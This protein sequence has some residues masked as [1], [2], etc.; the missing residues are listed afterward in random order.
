MKY[1]YIYRSNLKNQAG[2]AFLMVLFI[3]TM[4]ALLVVACG[5]QV[6]LALRIAGYHRDRLT[7][8]TYANSGVSRAVAFLDS[9][10]FANN[11]DALNKM[12]A[13]PVLPCIYA[14]SDEE[15]KININTAGEEIIRELLEKF[16]IE[17]PEDTA[18]NILIWRGDMPDT[19]SIYEREL[20]YGPKAAPFSCVEELTLVKGIN[21]EDFLK[22][23]GVV[24]VYGEG[25][26]NL[27]A[28]SEVVLGIIL[29]GIAGE[30][31]LDRDDAIALS[32]KII[33]IREES[34]NILNDASAISSSLSEDTERNLFAAFM[35][36][37][38][39]KSDNFMVAVTGNAGKI[40]SRI[41]FVYDR[42]N[43]E[44]SFRHES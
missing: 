22:I 28:V 20:G 21:P 9:S 32:A 13:P 23:R 31:S 40:K 34:G 1:R 5:R 6:S 4:L 10:D 7:A 27:N 17:F 36:R 12:P 37:A 24:T 44:I 35:E 3:T 2:Q 19:G 18:R 29:R 8:Y 33:K 30:M 15:G 38:A 42:R 25:R 16:K 39:L 11:Y 14:I 43:N 41:T 26:V